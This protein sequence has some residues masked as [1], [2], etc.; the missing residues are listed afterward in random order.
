MGITTLKIFNV[1]VGKASLNNKLYQWNEPL[2]KDRETKKNQLCRIAS[3]LQKYVQ[4]NV[5]DEKIDFL[6]TNTM[7][8][9]E[10]N[11]SLAINMKCTL[12]LL[13]V[14]QWIGLG[15]DIKNM[16]KEL[17][18]EVNELAQLEIHTIP[19]IVVKDAQQLNLISEEVVGNAVYVSSEQGKAILG[20]L[21]TL[22]QSNMSIDYEMDGDALK[23][24]PLPVVMSVKEVGTPTTRDVYVSYSDFLTDKF[25]IYLKSSNRRMVD[26][27]CKALT[28]REK[29]CVA[30][31]KRCEAR[32]VFAAEV[33]RK[34]N[35]KT[36]E[37]ITDIIEV[38]EIFEDKLC[39][40]QNEIDV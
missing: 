27:S 36:E 7:P 37:R 38:L 11:V 34:P 23:I 8:I 26:V 31:K 40:I 24:R 19:Q 15:E 25:G 14:E 2:G 32:V 12:N 33:I 39:P 22:A 30:N 9:R 28:Q 4:Q 17:I 3:N 18:T 21:I 16:M 35:G 5:P 6:V 13:T 29:L 1:I 20:E 10:P